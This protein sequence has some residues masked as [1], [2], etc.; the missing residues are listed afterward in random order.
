MS[1]IWRC[2]IVGGLL[3]FR[4]WVVRWGEDDVVR[5]K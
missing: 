2:C 1:G 5:L 3:M 4:G